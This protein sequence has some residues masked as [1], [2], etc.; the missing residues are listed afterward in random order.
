MPI[1]AKTSSYRGL[2]VFYKPLREKKKKYCQAMVLS[3]LDSTN[4]KMLATNEI[5]SFH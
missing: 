3:Q 4:V 2:A 5:Q 1:K